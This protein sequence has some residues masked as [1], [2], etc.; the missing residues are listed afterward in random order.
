MSLSRL[1]ARVWRVVPVFW[2]LRRFLLIVLVV[3]VARHRLPGRRFPSTLFGRHLADD[4]R[5]RPDVLGHCPAACADVVH[6]HVE[7]FSRVIGE[8][9][10]CKLQRVESYGGL[11]DLIDLVAEPTVASFFSLA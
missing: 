5:D 7:R 4:L 8:I 3:L 2:P 1:S 11:V 9:L 6:T 10:A